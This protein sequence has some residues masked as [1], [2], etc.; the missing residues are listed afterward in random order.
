MRVCSMMQG[1]MKDSYE[2]LIGR[3]ECKKS[4]VGPDL[5]LWVP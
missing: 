2:I 4:F 1:E 5:Q 3:L